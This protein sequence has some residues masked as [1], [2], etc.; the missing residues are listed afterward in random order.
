MSKCSK[1]LANNITERL[2]QKGFSQAE[3][4]RRAGVSQPFIGQILSL[5]NQSPGTSQLERI[6]E[7]LDTTLFNLLTTPEQRG[8][9]PL[10][11]FEVV[12]DIMA[13]VRSVDPKDIE[14]AL[15]R[16]RKK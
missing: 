1:I 12:R 15:R 13:L 9:H 14:E 7:A 5:H 16:L 10:D 6:A 4:A 3:L 11:C 8:H 2:K